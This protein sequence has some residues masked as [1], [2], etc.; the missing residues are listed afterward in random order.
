MT[1]RFPWLGASWKGVMTWFPGWPSHSF[2]IG[3]NHWQSNNGARTALQGRNFPEF[4]GRVTSGFLYFYL[5]FESWMLKTEIS[6]GSS[7]YKWAIQWHTE[8]GYPCY[9]ERHTVQSVE[10]NGVKFM[11]K[12]GWNSSQRKSQEAVTKGQVTGLLAKIKKQI[13][14]FEFTGKK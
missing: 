3:H 14:L 2:S 9:S 7:N 8:V 10:E 5:S 4:Q 6:R 1:L 13:W 12:T 11:W